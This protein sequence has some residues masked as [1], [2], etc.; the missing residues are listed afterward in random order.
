MPSEE[1]TV[2]MQRRGGKLIVACS[3][4]LFLEI[5]LLLFILRSEKRE[6]GCWIWL[7]TT[8]LRWR[9][10]KKKERTPVKMAVFDG[11]VALYCSFFL[12]EMYVRNFA[13]LI[14]YAWSYLFS[15]WSRRG[16]WRGLASFGD[17]WAHVSCAI[18]EQETRLIYS[19]LKFIIL[20][21]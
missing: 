13:L 20:S 11:L 12:L 15:L 16:H 14:G 19:H 5:K 9:P 18:W 8:G 4:L 2:T 6:C 21:Q 7:G 17:S 10:H 3:T 1:G